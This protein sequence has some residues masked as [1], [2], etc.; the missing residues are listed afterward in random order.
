M[1]ISRNFARILKVVVAGLAILTTFSFLAAGQRIADDNSSQNVWRPINQE[2]DEL[3][4]GMTAYKSGDLDE[5]ISHFQKAILLVPQDLTPRLQL[6]EALSRKVVS[7]VDSP[8]NLKIA[9]QAISVY[10]GVLGMPFPDPSPT[11]S[12]AHWRTLT[13]E[14]QIARIEFSIKKLDEAKKWQK[15]VLAEEP[16]DAEAAFAVGVIDWMQAHQT[17][18]AALTQAGLKDDGMGNAKAPA[19]VMAA[20]KT[21]N[22]ALIEESLR[23]LNQAVENRPD[24]ADAMAYLNLAYLRKADLDFGNEAACAEDVAKAQEWSRKAH[25]TRKANEEKKAAGA[26]AAKS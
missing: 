16:K 7:G 26:E 21:Q 18:Q 9:Q 14:K 5:A 2:Y 12:F 15:K 4:I 17:A 3:R 6:G 8:E 19:A 24:Y 23:Y 22:G 1:I 20:I 11:P 10:Q 25:E 13:A